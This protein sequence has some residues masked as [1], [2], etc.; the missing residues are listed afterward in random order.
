MLRT[1]AAQAVGA[2]IRFRIII[3]VQAFAIR[4]GFVVCVVAHL[5]F[6]SNSQPQTNGFSSQP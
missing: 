3:T 2:W 6:L 4:I 1:P 5:G